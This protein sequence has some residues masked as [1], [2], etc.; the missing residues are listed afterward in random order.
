M[1]KVLLVICFFGALF[2]Y[3]FAQQADQL[4][5]AASNGDLARVRQLISGGL[6]VDV[7]NSQNGWSALMYASQKGHL[8]VVQY[9][10]QRGANVNMKDPIDGWTS[11]LLASRGGHTNVVKALLEKNADASAIVEEKFSSVAAFSPL[12]FACSNGDVEM[13]RLLIERGANVNYIA[14]NAYGNYSPIGYACDKGKIDVVR[15]LLGYN[16]DLN[17]MEGLPLYLA[18]TKG[19]EELALLLINSG[20]NF[21][22]KSGWIGVFLYACGNGLIRVVETLISK[23]ANINERDDFGN[24][25][26]IYASAAGHLEIVKLLYRNG[27]DLNVRG[28]WSETALT[29]AKDNRRVDVV[30]WLTNNGAIE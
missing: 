8:E 12:I 21:R 25:G 22:I 23:G 15:L 11:V 20:A 1:K 26:I 2:G 16:V 7:Y 4:F 9:L 6:N 13:A 29:K 19:Y 14:V 27:G 5:T 28:P 24:T 30:I 18:V 3:A 17:V 10:I